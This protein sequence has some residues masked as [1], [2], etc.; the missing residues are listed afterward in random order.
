MDAEQKKL[1]DLGNQKDL[2]LQKKLKTI[3]NYV[4]DSVPI[5]NDEV[6]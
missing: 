3:G 1:E 4:D 2:L 6:R 5:S